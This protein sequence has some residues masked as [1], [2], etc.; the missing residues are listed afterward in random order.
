VC[1]GLLNFFFVYCRDEVN[2][3]VNSISSVILAIIEVKLPEVINA[4]SD[5]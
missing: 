5:S 4:S 1:S 2:R 3:N